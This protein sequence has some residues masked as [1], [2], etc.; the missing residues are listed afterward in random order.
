MAMPMGWR[1][2]TR[3]LKPKGWRLVR[4]SA[5]LMGL[6]S[7]K[8]KDLRSATR[9]VTPTVKLK[10]RRSAMHLDWHLVTRLGLPRVMPIRSLTGWQMVILT[11]TARRLARQMV[12]RSHLPTGLHLARRSQMRKVKLMVTQTPKAWH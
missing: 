7:A 2:P 6:R 11:Q 10:A 12:T 1:S 5:K 9:K 3:S 4:R 8:L